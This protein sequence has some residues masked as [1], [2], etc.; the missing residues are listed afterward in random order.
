MRIEIGEIE[1]ALTEHPCVREAAVLVR[2]GNAGDKHIVAYAVPKPE[3][4]VTVNE[5]QGHLKSKLP[6]H[7][8]PSFLFVLEAMALS[9]NGKID[10]QAL[11]AP[12]NAA[13]IVEES[14]VAPRTPV[15]ELITE[16]CAGALGLDQVGI[17]NNFFELGGHSL[18][19]MQ[20]VNQL[21]DTFKVDL[22]LRSVFDAGTIEELTKVVVANETTEGQTEKIAR[23][24]KRVRALS[25]QGK[26]ELLQ[27]RQNG[28]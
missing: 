22:P 5:L 27:V 6:A 17:R 11:P 23:V 12:N 1:S 15:E 4:S 13:V 9:V 19:A 16:M 7:M 26:K 20:F 21:R 18:S 2:D 25:Q 28:K 14:Y 24:I 3:H 10:R 8:I